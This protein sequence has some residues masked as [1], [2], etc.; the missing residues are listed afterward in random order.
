MKLRTS[1]LKNFFQYAFGI[2]LLAPI[3]LSRE[4]LNYPT[5]ILKGA[6]FSIILSIVFYVLDILTNKFIK[7]LK[8][9][10][11]LS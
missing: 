9:K 5:F 1:R 8:S 7:Q 3:V 6:I 11:G 2:W 10:K 4:V